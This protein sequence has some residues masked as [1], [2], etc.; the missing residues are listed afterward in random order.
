MASP[1]EQADWPSDPAIRRGLAARFIIAQDARWV[2]DVTLSASETGDGGAATVLLLSHHFVRI[3]FEGAV[4]IRSNN[5]RVGFPTLAGLLEDQYAAITTRA[6]HASKLLDDTKKTHEEVLSEIELM[7]K[8]MREAFLR[9]AP[10][11]L[12]G[13]ETDL[14]IYQIGS[15]VV[16][17]SV[18]TAYRLGLDPVNQEAMFG[19][20]TRD[21]AAEW[22]GSTVV[23][24]AAD[25]QMP[26]LRSSL[27]MSA[28][29][30][31]GI[32][33]RSDRYLASRYE[34]SFPERLKLLLLMIEGDLNCNRL[35]LPQTAVG[36][37]EAVFRARVVTL[38]H[39]LRALEV[40]SRKHSSLDSPALRDLRALLAD[41]P[42]QR[43][44]S[45]GSKQVRNRSMHY[46]IRSRQI[47]IDPKRPFFGL[48]E[49]VYPGAT[50]ESFDKD[51][52]GVTERLAV[53]FSTW[54]VADAWR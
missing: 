6:R 38:Y 26:E 37:E 52:V 8:R 41:E 45:P 47:A 18:P 15:A 42:T 44:L 28:I 34:E 16:G 49:A 50:F 2:Q 19:H 54:K 30:V 21:V 23:L 5:P 31:S 33:R 43:L 11:W 4:A 48:V 10:R 35:F 27:D 53:V 12:R 1:L 9:K 13:L 36:H 25:M 51:M 46:E 3:A 29:E 14:G 17:A 39:A 32:D 20:A 7:L 40:V 24:A 22:G